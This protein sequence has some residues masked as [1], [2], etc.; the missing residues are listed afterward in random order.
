MAN[1]M[2]IRL[3]EDIDRRP[4]TA[5]TMLLDRSTSSWPSQPGLTAAISWSTCSAPQGDL[6]AAERRLDYEGVDEETDLAHGEI[7]EAYL[8]PAFVRL[9]RRHPATVIVECVA[10]GHA[11]G[12]PVARRVVRRVQQGRAEDVSGGDAIGI[13]GEACSMTSA[14][15]DR[16]RKV[17]EAWWVLGQLV[18]RT[19]LSTRRFLAFERQP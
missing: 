18:V 4:I 8:V 9:P 17:V 7:V 19:S 2:N 16:R 5:V 1:L 15:T 6:C 13:V 14:M 3:D 10:S 12:R 11:L